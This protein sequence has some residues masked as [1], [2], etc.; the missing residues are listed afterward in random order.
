[1]SQFNDYNLKNEGEMIILE[2]YKDLDLLTQHLLQ[3][4]NT[5]LVLIRLKIIWFIGC[6]NNQ[7]YIHSLSSFPTF[8]IDWC[9][10]YNLSTVIENIV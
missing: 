7:L 2:S 5:D 3:I 8:Y 4:N 9:K 6:I 1:M 10:K